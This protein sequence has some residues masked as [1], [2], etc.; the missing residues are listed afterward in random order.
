M[1]IRRVITIPVLFVALS[2]AGG[3][4]ALA[5][6]SSGKSLVDLSSNTSLGSFLVT[7]G[8]LTLYHN[9]YEDNGGYQCTGKCLSAWKPLLLP[10]GMSAPTAGKGVVDKLGT[11]DRPGVGEQVTYD[12]WPLYTF[13]GD[14]SAGNTN[15][16]AIAKRWYVVAPQP[17]VWFYIHISSAAGEAASGCAA[18]HFHHGPAPI[19]HDARRA[20]TPQS[21]HRGRGRRPGRRRTGRRRSR[22]RRLPRPRSAHRGPACRPC[23]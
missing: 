17:H 19:R 9:I 4:L 22:P 18:A 21:F 11:V 2:S 16:E 10:Q 3:G 6:H 8:G 5:D 20:D 13:A 23:P 15:G 1:K 12:S 7:S 14:S